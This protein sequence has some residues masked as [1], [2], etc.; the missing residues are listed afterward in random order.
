MSDTRPRDLTAEELALLA[1]PANRGTESAPLRIPPGTQIAIEL[2]DPAGESTSA[3]T[4]PTAS[5]SD[6][7]GSAGGGTMK[8]TAPA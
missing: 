3:S 2:L 1:S 4:S 6:V 8:S 5:P 7:P